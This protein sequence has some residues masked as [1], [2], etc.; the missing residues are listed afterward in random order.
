MNGVERVELVLCLVR[1]YAEIVD[2]GVQVDPLHLDFFDLLSSGVGTLDGI[3]E[4]L[5]EILLEYAPDVLS[6]KAI[7]V[8]RY[9]AQPAHLVGDPTDHTLSANMI[10]GDDD[11]LGWV[12]DIALHHILPN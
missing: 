7:R 1:K 6:L 4:L 3:S 11:S 12:A 2:V 9:C 8:I 10:E 5:Q